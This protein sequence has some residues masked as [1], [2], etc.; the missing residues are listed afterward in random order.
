V[1][2][3]QPSSQITVTSC[4]DFYPLNSSAPDGKVGVDKYIM[5]SPKSGENHYSKSAYCV[6]VTFPEATRTFSCDFRKH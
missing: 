3:P 6:S 4:H 1:S 5:I 2:D